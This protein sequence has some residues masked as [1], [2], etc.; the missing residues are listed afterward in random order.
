LTGDEYQELA[1]LWNAA[2]PAADE[3]ELE[4]LARRTPRRAR[5]VQ[6]GELAAVLL[7]AV[8][9]VCSIIWKLG[10][11]SLLTGG[12][13]L[14]LLGW[15]AWRRHHLGNIA[16]LIEDADRVSFIRSTLRAKEA[17]H[18]RSAVGLALVLPGTLLTMLLGFSLRD[19]GGGD[20]AA[21]FLAVLTTPRGLIALGFLLCAV[22]LFTMT[23][24]RLTSELEALRRLQDEYA[25][26]ARRDQ[27][28]QP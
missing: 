16:L 24:A 14:L 10:P 1:G 5:L 17:E 13:I 28:T 27:F 18:N 23:H 4:R 19:G 8:T 20:L 21:F 22:L 3:R 6:W 11:A 2:A 15:S 25:R 26:E 7:L 9:I 12:L